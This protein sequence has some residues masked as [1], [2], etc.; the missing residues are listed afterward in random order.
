MTVTTCVKYKMSVCEILIQ[1][2]ENVSRNNYYAHKMTKLTKNIFVHILIT[3]SYMKGFETG[4]SIA[5]WRIGCC[6]PTHGEQSLLCQKCIFMNG[7][8]GYLNASVKTMVSG[9]KCGWVGS[10]AS[11]LLLVGNVLIGRF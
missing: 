2:Y 8:S 11:T 3:Y 1:C 6:F 4:M 7:D 5:L 10:S 9:S